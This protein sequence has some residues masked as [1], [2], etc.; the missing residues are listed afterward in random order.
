MKK[1]IWVLLREFA[2]SAMNTA[3]IVSHCKNAFDSGTERQGQAGLSVS[4]RC[5]DSRDGFLSSGRAVLHCESSRKKK[6]KKR[7]LNPTC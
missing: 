7:K 2:I 3:L 4:L 5:T 6:K 1:H